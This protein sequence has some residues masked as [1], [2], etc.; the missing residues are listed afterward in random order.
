MRHIYIYI[1]IYIYTPPPSYIYTVSW[2]LAMSDGSKKKTTHRKKQQLKTLRNQCTTPWPFFVSEC[3]A[4]Q[5][6]FAA[7]NRLGGNVELL[8]PVVGRPATDW[9]LAVKLVLANSALTELPC[10]PCQFVVTSHTAWK[11][12]HPQFPPPQHLAALQI[13]KRT[14]NS[15][16]RFVIVSALY[17]YYILFL[18][19]F[20]YSS[21]QRVYCSCWLFKKTLFLSTFV[22]FLSAFILFLLAFLYC[23]C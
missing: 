10:E 11:Q 1:Y 23:S 8:T 20:L 12:S 2:D 9:I 17:I 19:A 14:R 5:D 15:R 16:V 6:F 7:K 3:R 22:L 4:R 13:N 21:C 18:W